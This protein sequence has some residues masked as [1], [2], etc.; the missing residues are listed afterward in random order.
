MKLVKQ[1]LSDL[2]LGDPTTYKNLTVYPLIGNG[3]GKSQYLTL[4]AALDRD[5]ARV[6]EVSEGGSV[7]ELLFESRAELPILI[8]DGE[9]LVGAKQNRTANLTI[10]APPGTK[11]VIPVSCVEAGRWRRE[12]TDFQVSERAHFARGRAAKMASVSHSIGHGGS[13]RSDQGRV[14]ADIE[15][16]A[17]EMGAESPTRAMAAIFDRHRTKIEDFVG[18]FDSSRN[19]TG[20]IFAIGGK[21]SGLDLFDHPDTLR[22][23]LPKLIRSYAV[24]AIGR[25]RSNNRRPGKKRAGSFLRK[26]TNS[27]YQSYAAVGLG[28]DIRATGEAIVAGG[29]IHDE[30]L[31]HLA[32]FAVPDEPTRETRRDG[33]G[34]ASLNVRRNTRRRR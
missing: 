28:T 19:Q 11:T 23:M 6:R 20:A 14:W 26:V 16:K 9:E 31:I 7:P 13:R 2:N 24:D 33:R 30:R 27:Q 8:V 18:A 22:V 15:E 1:T 17:G 29:L 10:L 5:L 4:G 12:S 32:A 21:I 34:M 25:R 3:T